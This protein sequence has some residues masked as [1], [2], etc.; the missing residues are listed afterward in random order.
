MALKYTNDSEI[1]QNGHQN[2]KHMYFMASHSK[3]YPNWNFWFQN[4]PTG[5][6]AKALGLTP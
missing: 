3:I 2:Y 1:N 5:N 4:M 6:P